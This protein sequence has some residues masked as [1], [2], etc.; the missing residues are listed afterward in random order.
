[1]KYLD[2]SSD[3]RDDYLNFSESHNFIGVIY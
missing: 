2:D 1:L 3:D